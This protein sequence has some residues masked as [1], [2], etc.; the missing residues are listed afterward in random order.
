VAL[1]VTIDGDADDLP[2]ADAFARAGAAV[3]TLVHRVATGV[4]VMTP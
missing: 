2:L 3:S 1:R 4:M